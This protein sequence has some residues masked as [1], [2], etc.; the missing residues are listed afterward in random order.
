MADIL[1]RSIGPRVRIAL[2][3]PGELSPVRAD[4][5]QL[6]MAILNLSVNA[7]DAMPAGGVLTIVAANEIIGSG[8]DTRL[9]PGSY[10]RLSIIDTGI[11]MDEMVRE[12][13]VEPFFTTKPLGEGTGLGLSMVDGLASQMG[14]AFR[15]A[16]E[17]GHGTTATLWLPVWN[18]PVEQS[19]PAPPT[20]EVRGA[21]VALL[22]DDHD[23][24]RMSTSEML[25]N[26]GYEVVEARS[27]EEAAELVARGLGIDLLVTDHVMPGMSG[28][29]LARM[30]R[31]RRPGLPVLLVSGFSDPHGLP[32]DLPCLTKPFRKAQLA[33]KVAALMRLPA[34]SDVPAPFETA[35][36]PRRPTRR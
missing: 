36:L 19:A 8:H 23:L 29:D 15:L 27:G 17:R 5:N 2:D 28:S 9:P 31:A 33:E 35:R 4:A 34:N 11:G 12:R 10:V 30:A 14:G 6:E 1:A 13:A 24:V 21:G 20:T 18:D 22:V 32:P 16:S 7:R 3:L 25:S 26:L